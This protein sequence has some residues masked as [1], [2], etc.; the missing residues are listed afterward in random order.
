[1]LTILHGGF[2]LQVNCYI[3][4]TQETEIILTK[5]SNISYVDFL[6]CVC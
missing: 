5:K 6:E 2:C 4:I 3:S 1:M